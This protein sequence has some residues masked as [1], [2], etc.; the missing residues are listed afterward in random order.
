[1]DRGVRGEPLQRGRP[2]KVAWRAAPTDNG[3]IGIWGQADRRL[4]AGSSWLPFC[5]P[6]GSRSLKAQ[7]SLHAVYL[8]EL[9]NVPEVRVDISQ[10][11]LKGTALNVLIFGRWV[12]LRKAHVRFS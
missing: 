10:Q 12:D 8:D 6:A 3:P 7:R 4:S 9:N 11:L 2:S 1:M 5:R